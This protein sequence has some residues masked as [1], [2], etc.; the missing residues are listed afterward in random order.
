MIM[1]ERVQ[2]YRVDQTLS[3]SDAM[4]GGNQAHYFNVGSSA[5]TS[6]LHAVSIAETKPMS[7]LDFGCGAGRV[8]R[9]IV[10]AFP[11]A[12]VEG[13]DIREADIKFVAETFGARTW[14]SGIDVANLN[15]PSTYDLIWVGSVFTH[16]SEEVSV[17]LFD[18]LTSWLNPKG[19]L[20]VTSHGRHAASRGTEAGFYGIPTQWSK[21]LKDYREFEY[22]YAD[23]PDMAG[24][25]ISLI[26][27]YWWTKLTTSRP[28]VRLLS[29]TEQAWDGHQD[30]I[31]VQSV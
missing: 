20:V 5:L 29:M 18:K 25:G 10:A 13:C 22:G 7:I 1:Q 2:N 14:Q 26:Q 23:Y 11:Q 15:P 31:A 21:V 16:L 6:I 9:W 24:Y 8:T 28:S 27:L 19:I 4:Y 30:V 12:K 3:P 17:Q